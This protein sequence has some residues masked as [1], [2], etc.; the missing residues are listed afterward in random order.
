MPKQII[1][2]IKL[3]TN[4]KKNPDVNAVENKVK[5]PLGIDIKT[6][7]A[8]KSKV[9][10]ESPSNKKVETGNICQNC[11]LGIKDCKCLKEK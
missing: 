9:K 5:K 4:F 3:G 2:T 10:C 7:N 1:S 6:V 11:S 8:E